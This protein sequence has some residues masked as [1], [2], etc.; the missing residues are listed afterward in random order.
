MGDVDRVRF[1]SGRAVMHLIEVTVLIIGVAISMVALN[2]RLAA[3]TL[4]IV[5]FMGYA[6][7]EF[8]R[9]FRPL[10]RLMRGEM[11]ALTTRLEQNLRGARIVKAFAQQRAEIAR[12]DEQNTRVLDLNVHASR[13]RAT[14]LPLLQ[15]FA[16]AGTIVVLLHGGRLAIDGRA[17]CTSDSLSPGK[18]TIEKPDHI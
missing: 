14:S 17:T 5:P 7:F 4:V 1:L 2:A 8:G 16:S 12:F 13:M 10:F 15:L 6:A 11:D 18:A 9:R 3:L